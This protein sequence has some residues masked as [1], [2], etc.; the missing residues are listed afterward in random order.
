MMNAQARKLNLIENLIFLQDEK[1]LEKIESFFSSF[2]LTEKK[3]LKI[4]KSLLEYKK[5]I[6]SGKDIKR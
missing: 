1:I 5:K 6:L 3:A 2:Q 4:K